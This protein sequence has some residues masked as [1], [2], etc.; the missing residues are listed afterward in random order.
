VRRLREGVFGSGET[1]TDVVIHSHMQVAADEIERLRAER[2][3]LRDALRYWLHDGEVRDFGEWFE[4]GCKI[5]RA[6]LKSK[7]PAQHSGRRDMSDNVKQPP[8]TDTYQL[9][10]PPPRGCICPPG[11]NRDCESP[12]CPRKPLRPLWGSVQ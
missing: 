12:T 7:K 4:V 2:D 10:P 11:A 9:D 5:A 1:K 3:R 6:A 8:A